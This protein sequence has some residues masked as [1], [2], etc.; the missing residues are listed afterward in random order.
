MDQYHVSVGRKNV[1]ITHSHDRQLQ[2]SH[3]LQNGFRYREYHECSNITFP[4]AVLVN[5]YHNLLWIIYRSCRSRYLTAFNTIPFLSLLYYLSFFHFA[6]KI[7]CSTRHQF[8]THHMKRFCC[9]V[10]LLQLSPIVDMFL[11]H[12]YWSFI[13]V[14]VNRNSRYRSSVSFCSWISVK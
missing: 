9:I 1:H 3:C 2:K 4:T 5:F 10:I 6:S 12:V 7:T 14:E 11:G 8:S 13:W